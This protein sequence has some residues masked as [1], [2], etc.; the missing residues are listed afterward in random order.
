MAYKKKETVGI[1]EVVDTETTQNETIVEETKKKKK[2]N[3]EDRIP[4]AST[5]IGELFYT[6]MKSGTLY[7]FADIDDVVDIEFRD[8]DY[9]ARSKEPMM[10]KPRF[11]VLDD[12]F[13]ALHA[14]LAELY[15]A[16]YSSADLRNILKMP[17]KEMAKTIVT[18]PL[19]VQDSLKTIASTMIDNGTLD[20]VQRIKA[21]D[22]IFGTE[23]L[24]KLTSIED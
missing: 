3:A 19:S 23:M 1:K 4:C 8:L 10:F 15:T 18:L 9:A 21:L 7:T 16:K 22:S 20:S 12:D 13:V 6:G 24:M 2:F 17:A 11:V 5:T 14:S